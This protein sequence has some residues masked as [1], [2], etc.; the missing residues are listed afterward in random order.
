MGGRWKPH[1]D[2]RARGGGAAVTLPPARREKRRKGGW[3]SIPSHRGRGRCLRRASRHQMQAAKR[4]RRRR[5]RPERTAFSLPSLSPVL[6]QKAPSL[7]SRRKPPS[8]EWTR[9]AGRSVAAPAAFPPN[10]VWHF[11]SRGYRRRRSQSC[12]SL[13]TAPVGLAERAPGY[14]EGGGTDVRWGDDPRQM[15]MH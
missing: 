2:G 7:R 5:R 12:S 6:S 4:G 11:G 1:Q 8:I 3:M 10:R 15:C 14:E 13:G 9:P